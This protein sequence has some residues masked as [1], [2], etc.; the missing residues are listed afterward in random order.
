MVSRLADLVEFVFKTLWCCAAQAYLLHHDDTK[1]RLRYLP[2]TCRTNEVDKHTPDKDRKGRY[3]TGIVAKYQDQTIVLF[4]TGRRHAGENLG[5]LLDDRD[6]VQGPPL[7]MCDALSR[8]IP[9]NH[10]I[11]LCNCNTHA[12]RQFVDIVDIF[13]AQCT[14]IIEVM[15]DIYKNDALTKEQN[16]S[17]A[18]RLV[19]HQEHS[20]PLMA[21]LREWLQQQLEDKLVESNSSLGDAIKYMLRHWPALTMFLQVEGAPLDNNIVER[22]LKMV[23][24]HRKNAYFYRTPRGAHVGDI[25]MSII[26]TCA[27]AG[28]NPMEYLVALQKN[29]TRVRAAPDQWLPW[30][31]HLALKGNGA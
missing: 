20:K 30:N 21:D 2:T 22:A 12:R 8:N 3:T 27:H 11:R 7:V 1:A 31:F 28:V 17:A 10:P 18:Q 15:R 5:R 19:Y 9:T 13:P 14:H 26:A 29:A 6:P 25:F 16:L 23:V 24:L 4:Q